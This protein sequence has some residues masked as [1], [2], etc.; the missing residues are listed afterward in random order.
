MSCGTPLE[1]HYDKFLMS[2][3]YEKKESKIKVVKPMQLKK[4][5]NLRIKN[6]S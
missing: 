4:Y 5:F 6:I 2:K 3:N 1:E